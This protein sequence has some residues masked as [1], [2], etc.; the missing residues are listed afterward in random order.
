M[1]KGKVYIVGAGPGDPELIT[2]KGKKILYQCDVV[3][4]DYLVDRNILRYSNKNCEFICAD[5]LNGNRYSDGFLRKQKLIN[6]LILKKVNDGKNV[7]RLK[8]GDP[9]IFG[10]AKEELEFLEENNIEYYIV[11]GITSANCASCYSGVPLTIRNVSSS[12]IFLTGHQVENP[13]NQLRW[14]IISKLETIVF[15]MGVENMKK[16][17]DKLIENGMD[18]KTPFIVISNVSKVQQ[19]IFEGE[20][21]NAEDVYDKVKPPAIII[22]GKVIKNR[23]KWFEKKKKVLFFGISPKRYF[24]DGIIFHIPLIEIKELDD[25]SEFDE[26]LRNIREYDWIIFT[27]RFGV[28]YFFKRFF[29]IGLDSRAL[30]NIKIAAIGN[31]TGNKLK[32]YGII[33][34][35]IPIKESSLGLIEE[36]K[37]IDMKNKKIFLPRSDLS[38]KGLKIELEKMGCFV[39]SSICYKNVMPENIPDIDFSLF[40]EIIF[41]SPS[42]V[43]NFKKRFKRLPEINIK[44]IGEVTEKAL[45]EEFFYEKI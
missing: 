21:C 23:F 1:K 7:V 25:Y 45:K 37:K 6:E 14:D 27:S 30:S 26:K 5:E 2:L 35:I 10:R 39:T 43:R 28:I 18:K 16:I 11:P 24:E 29:S 9:F 31:S 32:K 8:N 12:V 3:I 22:I 17:F 19:R 34:D 40:D 41:T 4:Y 44:C 33:P 13:E 20:I 38:D 42:T 36:F 15:Y